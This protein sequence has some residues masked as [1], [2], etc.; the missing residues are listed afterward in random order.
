MTISS[1]SLIIG[2]ALIDCL[3]PATIAT[4]IVLLPLVSKRWHSMVFVVGTFLMYF[5]AGLLAFFGINKYLL[6]SLSS[7]FWTY[8]TS[9]AISEI[10]IS[11]MLL[12]FGVIQT[13][14]LIRQIT[15]K[16]IKIKDFMGMVVKK[17]T[18]ISILM[19][20]I[21]STLA[22]L[23]TAIP[24]FGF[25]GILNVANVNTATILVLFAL[26][27]LIYTAPMILL[28]G[29]Y[30]FMSGDRLIKIETGF[31]NFINKASFYSIPIMLIIFG[32]LIGI[33]GASRLNLIL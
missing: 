10:A 15:S 25:V 23:P 32:I 11:I 29:V 17:V 1:F 18:P 27:C 16:D 4:M 2:L 24:Y 26:Y 12:V 13:Y 9:I 19:L 30:S 20:A 14:K 7:I 8:S 5:S 28:Y 21:V 3:N 22:D 31:K 33:D 6:D